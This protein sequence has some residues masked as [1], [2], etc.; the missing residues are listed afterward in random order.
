MTLFTRS[1]FFKVL[2]LA[3]FHFSKRFS[4]ADI[5]KFA[6]HSVAPIPRKPILNTHYGLL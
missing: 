3:F 6:G 1:A 2:L 4:L 5:L